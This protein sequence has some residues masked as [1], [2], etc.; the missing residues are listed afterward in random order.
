[1]RYKKR[2][3]FQAQ[4]YSIP[5]LAQGLRTSFRLPADPYDVPDEHWSDL[6]AGGNEA[7]VAYLRDLGVIF[8][9]DEYN[10]T[11]IM[12]QPDDDGP[13]L[14]ERRHFAAH[15]HALVLSSLTGEPTAWPPPKTWD[16]RQ[17]HARYCKRKGDDRAWL[18]FNR[19]VTII[20]MTD[21][22]IPLAEKGYPTEASG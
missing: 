7:A 3:F 6:D 2:R 9:R 5:K 21:V 1:M 19:E 17:K 20:Q 11:G 22:R 14:P 8:W 13:V 10:G 18:S 4:L 12:I 15:R 16:N